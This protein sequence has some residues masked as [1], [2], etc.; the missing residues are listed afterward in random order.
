MLIN[1]NDKKAAHEKASHIK[2]KCTECLWAIELSLKEMYGMS[3]SNWR[4][5]Q[6]SLTGELKQF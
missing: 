6:L 4:I 5:K 2:D 1:E 3:M